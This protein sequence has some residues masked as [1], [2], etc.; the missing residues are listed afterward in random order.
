VS[1]A[2]SDAAPDPV[3][4]AVAEAVAPADGG[5]A[6]ESP[7]PVEQAH[8]RRL[9]KQWEDVI[10][11]LCRDFAPDGGADRKRVLAQIAQQRAQLDSA[12]VRDYLPVLVDR[13]VRRIY[14]PDEQV[15]RGSST[16]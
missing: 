6:A 15:Q 16:G 12:T 4:E 7:D 9:A 1:D 8:R 5:T 3:A 2:V 10:S 14:A 13:A 11:R